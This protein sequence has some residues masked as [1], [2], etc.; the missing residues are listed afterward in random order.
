[1]QFAAA[2]TFLHIRDL[3]FTLITRHRMGGS[4]CKRL[5]TSTENW[6]CAIL[7]RRRDTPWD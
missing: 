2:E 6:L 5:L 3:A 7:S 1:V 4:E